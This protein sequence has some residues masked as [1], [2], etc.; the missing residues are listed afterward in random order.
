MDVDAP[1]CFLALF[2]SPSL[3]LVLLFFLDAIV[4]PLLPALLLISPPAPAA[5]AAVSGGVVVV[6][7]DPGRDGESEGVEAVVGV[8]GLG[9]A[10]GV[11][12]SV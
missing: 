4:K 5:A 6:M 8:E 12:A 11:V 3:A 9:L 10:N 7:G 1:R 2:S